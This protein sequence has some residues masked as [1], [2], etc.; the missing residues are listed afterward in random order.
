MKCLHF[1]LCWGI[2]DDPSSSK[3]QDILKK[4]KN[5]SHRER[6]FA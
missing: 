2:Y 6:L 5:K 1:E 3:A 4:A